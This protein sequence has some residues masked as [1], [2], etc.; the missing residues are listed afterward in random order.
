[1]PIWLAAGSVQLE[2]KIYR[3]VFSA[4]FPEKKVLKVWVDDEKRRAF[5]AELGGG[6]RLV[7]EP[8]RAD[9]LIL[10]KDRTITLDKP[11]IA[12]RYTILKHYAKNAVAGFYWKK[13]RPHLLFVK[14][15]L[16][17]YHMRLPQDMQRYIVKKP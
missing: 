14:P 13:G 16:E 3:T 12:E 5:F 9:A 7:E 8:D 11:V 10:K 1:M 4:L 15:A 6:V 17:R 2:K